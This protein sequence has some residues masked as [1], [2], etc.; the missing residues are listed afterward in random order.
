MMGL[1]EKLNRNHVGL[2]ELERNTDGTINIYQYYFNVISEIQKTK[3]SILKR[4]KREKKYLCQQM[5]YERNLYDGNCYEKKRVTDYYV[6][7]IR[8][9]KRDEKIITEEIGGN[10]ESE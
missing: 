7:L 8:Q 3:A 10:H 5:R 4:Y 2:G 1:V 9:I 6:G